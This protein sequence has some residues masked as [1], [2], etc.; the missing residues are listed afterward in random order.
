MSID[1]SLLLKDSSKEE[2]VSIFKDALEKSDEAPFWKEK[3]L[4][5]IDAMLSVLIALREQNLLFTPEGHTKD[6]LDEELFLKWSDL[7]SLRTLAFILEESNEKASLVRT[8]YKENNYTSIDLEILASY[9]NSYR[10]NLSDE[11][12][13]DFPVSNYNLHIGMVTVVKKLLK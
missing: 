12:N 11:G 3:I 10:V 2:I 1:L 13:L 4:P 9:L 8:D 5:L 6:I 7:I